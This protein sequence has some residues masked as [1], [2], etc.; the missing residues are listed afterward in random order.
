MARAGWAMLLVLVLA[1]GVRAADPPDP[2]AQARLFY[3]QRDFV[4]AIAA[5]ERLR[6]TAGLADRADLIGARAYLERYRDGAAVED[7]NSARERL[8][9]LDP[10][11][12]EP[13][14]RTEYIVGLGEALYF[15]QAFGAAAEVFESVLVNGEGLDA[16]AR[17][18]VLDWWAIAVDREAWLRGTTIGSDPYEKIRT[19]MREES[20]IRPESA[21]AG[22]WLAAA[23]RSQ[24]DFDGAWEAVQ[25]GWVRAS[26]AGDRGAALRADLDKLMLVAIVPERARAKSQPD[27]ELLLEWERFKE[28]WAY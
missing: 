25:A 27:D 21:T 24:G 2:L 5:A 7:L 10:R 15:D 13:R 9:R 8:R 1:P 4:G 22:Y 18:R 26:L 17:D 28:R 3:N 19:R 11:A 6:E 12:F 23:A 16:E 14:E 20:A